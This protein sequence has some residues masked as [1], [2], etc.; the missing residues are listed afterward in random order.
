M[1]DLACEGEA[2]WA[3]AALREDLERDRTVLGFQGWTHS[4]G[5]LL[6]RGG[7][8]SLLRTCASRGT[9]VVLQVSVTGLGGTVLEPGVGP[10]EVE[11][12]GL[13]R[14]MEALGVGWEHVSVRIDPLQ[15][16]RLADG[17]RLT[18]L[19]DA[20]ALLARTAVLGVR[21]FR[22]SVIQYHRYRARIDPRLR[23]RD[24]EILRVTEEQR[25]RVSTALA[26][27]ARQAGA[28]LHSCAYDL[29][30]LKP[31]ACFDLA[32]LRTLCTLPEA[33]DPSFW[34]PDKAVA[35]RAGC[36][37]SFPERARLFKIPLRS[38]CPGRCAACY[39]QA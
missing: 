18:N 20:P 19:H 15:A 27:A 38:P 14:L 37:C 11:L 9:A 35:P 28:E 39:A 33:D 21:R 29:P 2:E 10:V 32:W 7:L 36:R 25:E 6:E 5:R 17:T 4:P 24:L 1:S 16:F 22:T 12:E 31:G 23:E 3:A 8:I 34:T 13:V 26:A 30:D